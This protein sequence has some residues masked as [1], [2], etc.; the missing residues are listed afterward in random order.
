MYVTDQENHRLQR[1]P[2]NATTS[3][4]VAGASNAATGASLIYLSYPSDLAVDSNENLYAVDGGNHRVVFWA[5]NATTG[6]LVAGTGKKT[7]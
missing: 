6:V 7:C 5:R 2:T 3:T 4:I 1:W